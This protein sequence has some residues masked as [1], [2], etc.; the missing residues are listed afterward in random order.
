M[1]RLNCW[2]ILNPCDGIFGQ[3]V[4][5]IWR[6]I[7]NGV[8]FYVNTGSDSIMFKVYQRFVSVKQSLSTV[9]S[10][11]CQREAKI[12]NRENLR[13]FLVKRIQIRFW[14]PI[15]QQRKKKIRDLTKR[16]IIICL[17]FHKQSHNDK[18]IQVLYL[19][20]NFVANIFT[21][22][23]LTFIFIPNLRFLALTCELMEGLITLLVP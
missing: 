12:E 20:T 23:I 5:G 15:Y 9:L 17:D 14:R 2:L 21:Y 6:F 19:I 3:I 13:E 16:L 4:E 11:V 1:R 10:I 7:N 18:L 22:I 8:F